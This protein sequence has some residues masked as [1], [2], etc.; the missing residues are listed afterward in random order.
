MEGLGLAR[1]MAC[2]AVTASL[3]GVF[4]ARADSRLAM[5]PPALRVAPP[6]VE[7]GASSVGATQSR[8]VRVTNVSDQPLTL[9]AGWSTDTTLGPGFG[10]PTGDSCLQREIEILQASQ[11]CTVTFTF[12]PVTAGVAEAA[13]VFSIDGWQSIESRVRLKGKGLF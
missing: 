5:G 13:F 2:V 8:T 1:L 6:V 3:V 9:S 7:F 12:T 4:S 10:F 11:S